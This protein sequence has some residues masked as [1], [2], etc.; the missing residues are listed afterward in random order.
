MRSWI[1]ECLITISHYTPDFKQDMFEIKSLEDCK[2][3]S[4]RELPYFVEIA[5]QFY[6]PVT[7]LRL[8]NRISNWVIVL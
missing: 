5:S 2:S 1:G 6:L 8:M 4:R 7:S 3:V